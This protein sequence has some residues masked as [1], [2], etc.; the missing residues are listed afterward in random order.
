VAVVWICGFEMQS[1]REGAPYPAAANLSIDTT[2][3]RSGNAS[4]KVIAP[5]GTQG[6]IELYS[7]ANSG[8]Y[9][10]FG[11]RFEAAPSVARQIH[12]YAGYAGWITV[13]LNADLTLSV[14][15]NTTLIGTTSFALTAGT[16]YWL[17]VRHTSG[18]GVFLQVDDVDAVSGT[19]STDDSIGSGVLGCQYTEASA[20]T[21][22]F[23]DFIASTDGFLPGTTKMALL[24]PASDG[25]RSTLWTNGTGGTTNLYDAVNNI[26]PAGLATET[27]TSQIEHAGG[28]AGTLD[29]YVAVM[30]SY[31]TAGLGA[32]DTV[33]AV[34]GLIVWGEDVS[35][36]TKLLSY[37][38]NAAPTWT[39]ESSIDVSTG[40]G[41]G[42]TLNYLSATPDNW[43]E[44]H[45]AVKTTGLGSL[46]GSSAEMAV[47][48]PETASRVAS[49]CFMGM[50][51][52]WTPYVEPPV[53][54]VVPRRVYP[55]LIPH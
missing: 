35:T 36:G 15:D 49:V 33:I 3:K 21:L 50:Y 22:W 55:Q 45:S 14:Y 24:V 48:R 32:S 40:D 47:N 27:A 2:I 53:S 43:N 20:L 11:F 8:K 37:Y 5:S 17:G 13:R 28:A 29:T 31:A 34:Q 30:T 19:V 38:G 9:V 23:D 12:G 52:V 51:V 6:A 4:I 26:P 39:G 7:G 54:M 44:R 46:Y 16:W 42:A 1:K 18:T 41:S 25:S 10:N